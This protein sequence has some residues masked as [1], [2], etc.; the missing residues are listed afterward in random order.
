MIT[1]AIV[2]TNEKGVPFI[3]TCINCGAENLKISDAQ[4]ECP[5]VRGE[6]NKENLIE[7]LRGGQ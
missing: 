5:N 4:K 2:R 7:M 1:H 3:G 6:T